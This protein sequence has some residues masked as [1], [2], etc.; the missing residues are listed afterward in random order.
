M[1]NIYQFA[2]V[3]KVKS[4][5]SF[6]RAFE[7]RLAQQVF[8][9]V[10]YFHYLMLSEFSAIKAV[11]SG[12]SKSAKKLLRGNVPDLSMYKDVSDFFLE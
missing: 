2:S 5:F 11:P 12:I 6:R 9:A 10:K 1:K 8:N 7:L 4:F 3:R